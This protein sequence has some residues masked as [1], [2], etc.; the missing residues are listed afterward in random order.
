MGLGRIT[1]SNKISDD[2]TCALADTVTHTE[3]QCKIAAAGF[4]IG[5]L[6]DKAIT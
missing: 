6:A 4:V 3:H 5:A 2:V 1:L